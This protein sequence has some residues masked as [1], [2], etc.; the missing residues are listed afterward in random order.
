MLN[1]MREK[2]EDRRTGGGR[3]DDVRDHGL[4]RRL[5]RVKPPI[6]GDHS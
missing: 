6:T 4:S 3:R 2:N 1:P 5:L